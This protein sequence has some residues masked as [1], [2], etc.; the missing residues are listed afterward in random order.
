MYTKVWEAC[1]SS[2]CSIDFQSDAGTRITTF[3]AFK[4]KDFLVTDDVIYEMDDDLDKFHPQ[5]FSDLTE[6]FPIAVEPTRIDEELRDEVLWVKGIDNPQDEEAGFARY[7]WDVN[8]RQKPGKSFLNF[9][10]IPII[11]IFA[12]SSEM[13]LMVLG[14][15]YICLSIQKETI[16]KWLRK[17]GF[18][19]TSNIADLAKKDSL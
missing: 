16:I 8:L 1:R 12:M 4:I 18:W 11:P 3:T 13:N 7:G 19:R 9:N 14:M 2:V 15:F 17:K 5:E 10:F 6:R